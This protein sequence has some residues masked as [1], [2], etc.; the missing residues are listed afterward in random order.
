[1]S[2]HWQARARG[3]HSD[4]DVLC[5]C[6]WA[7]SAGPG[8]AS[9][10]QLKA[11]LNVRPGPGCQP[12]I[13]AGP[14]SASAPARGRRPGC[15]GAV[16]ALSRARPGVRV[17]GPGPGPAAGRPPARAGRPARHRGSGRGLPVRPPLTVTG[18][19][20]Q[21]VSESRVAGD[22]SD[23]QLELQLQVELSGKP[24]PEPEPKFKKQRLPQC[25]CWQ[26]TFKLLPGPGTEHLEVT[27]ESS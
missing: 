22:A 18:S 13:A 9:L 7:C 15:P 2:C 25:Q 11:N 3:P 21:A 23:P 12:G 4:S 8:P 6:Q 24:E 17:R 16:T 10:W 1:V 27:T 26:H 20:A 14:A 19:E 5:Q